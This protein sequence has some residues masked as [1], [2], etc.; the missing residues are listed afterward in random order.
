MF[1]NFFKICFC[2]IFFILMPITVFAADYTL[3]ALGNSEETI[4]YKSSTEENFDNKV[5]V[6]VE[7]PS[8]YKITIPKT[9]V[10]SGLYKKAN[11]YV[12]VEGDLAD[13]TVVSVVPDETIEF[14][15]NKRTAT[16]YITQDKTRWTINDLDTDAI[17]EIDVTDL[18]A[19]IWEGTF[20]FDVSV[21]GT[22]RVPDGKTADANDVKTWL[23]CANIKNKSYTD[24]NDVLNDEEVLSE[25]LNND[26]ANDYLCRSTDWIDDICSDSDAME[27]I[28]R[29]NYAANTLLDSDDWFN[30]ICSS[31]YF[32]NVLNTSVPT[33]TNGVSSE[34]TVFS[35]SILDRGYPGYKAF[36]KNPADGW[37]SN[38]LVN[39]EIGFKFNEPVKVN[40]AQLSTFRYD[41]NGYTRIKNYS[42]QGSNDGVNYTTLYNGS[43]P[44]NCNGVVVTNTFKNENY[45]TYYRI[46]I[47]D[48]YAPYGYAYIGAKDVQFFGRKNSD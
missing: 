39:A 20:Y 38:L 9:I 3:D 48:N 26:N 15:S 17:G 46:F 44:N 1:K 41:D 32:E 14:I 24:I 19:G 45:Y 8:S 27:Y 18:T 5:D 11:Y 7:I 25:L 33:I 29:N 35:S 28:G 47:L 10:I 13:D 37:L 2:T 4:V 21:T 16:G 36:N 30:A 6:F 23:K 31:N 12:S 34:G 22:I 43:Y 40:K 42:I